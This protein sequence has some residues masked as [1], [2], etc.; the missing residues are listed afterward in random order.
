MSKTVSVNHTDSAISG[1][2]VLNL[3]RGLVNFAADWKVKSNQPSEVVI[4]NMT[5]PVAYPERFRF[6]LGDVK[7]VYAGSGIAPTLYTP[8]RRG[9]SLLCQLTGNWTVTDT[10]DASFLQVLPVSAHLVLKLPVNDQITAAMVQTLV[11]RL[12]SGLYETGLD[13]TSR[14]AALLRG[15]L[16]PADLI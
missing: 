2:S 13:T 16:I 6:S 14:Y 5:S 8:D 1:V 15:S 11:A 9:M 4:T 7:D 12:V 10:T 3:S